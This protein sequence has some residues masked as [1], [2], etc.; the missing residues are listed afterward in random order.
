VIDLPLAYNT[1][2]TD[3][4]GSCRQC[5]DACPTQALAPY[6]IDASRCLAHLT[7]ELKAAMPKEFADQTEGWAFGCD[8]CQEVCPWNRFAQAHN[9][10]EFRPLDPILNNTYD[11]WAR[12]T[13]NQFKKLLRDSPL[14]RVTYK[15]WLN[16]LHASLGRSFAQMADQPTHF[17]H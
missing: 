13:G 3:H 8:I 15:K 6:Q 2:V 5:I 17:D 12:Y 4:C 1:P 11:D 10:P 9:E 14:S 7:I 16:N